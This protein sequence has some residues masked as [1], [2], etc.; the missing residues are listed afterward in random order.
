MRILP[1]KVFHNL[2]VIRENISPAFLLH[3]Q[4]C[5]DTSP[6]D[7][8]RATEVT[9]ALLRPVPAKLLVQVWVVWSSDVHT[10]HIQ[11]SS[12]YSCLKRPG[13]GDILG[14]CFKCNSLG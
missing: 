9:I 7:R 1:G 14:T 13:S 10:G 3:V 6:W 4:G 2:G 11:L 8:G 12:K 5:Q